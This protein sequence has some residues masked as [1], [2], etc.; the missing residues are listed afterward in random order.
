MK[1][2]QITSIKIILLTSICFSCS[3]NTIF[4][5]EKNPNPTLNNTCT[6]SGFVLDRKT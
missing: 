4:K 1:H 2:S 3:M 6:I 5:L